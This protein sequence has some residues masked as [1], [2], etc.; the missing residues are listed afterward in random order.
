M[1]YFTI[2]N[3]TTGEIVLSGQCPDNDFDL[4]KL[5]NCE[6]IEGDGDFLSNYVSNGQIQNYTNEQKAL[7]SQR[8]PSFYQWSN[9]TF[10]WVDTR[11][12]DQKK[13]DQIAIVD[14]QRSDLLS[15]SDWIVIRATDQGTPIPKD[16]Q[17]YRQALRDIPTQSGYPFN[18]V[19]P[20]A[21]TTN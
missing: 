12:D 1:K 17:T 20:T 11:T 19:W 5:P 18:V 16:W 13:K 3:P 14:L 4:Q 15:S 7:K 9:Q 6:T 21:P 2:Y 8:M 10:N